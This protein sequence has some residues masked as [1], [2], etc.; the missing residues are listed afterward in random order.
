[1]KQKRIFYPFGILLMFVLLLMQFAF[2]PE[3]QDSVQAQTDQVPDF[4]IQGP[5]SDAPVY[6]TVFNGDLRHLSQLT[7]DSPA[8]PLPLKYIPGQEPK[9]SAPQLAG[10]QD[11]VIQA[12][13]GSG[14]MPNPI[15]NF[16]GL[17]FNTFGSGHPPDT[18]G[19]VGPNHYIQTVN[20]SIGIYDKTTGVRL[21]G[22]SFNNFFQGGTACNTSNSG[23]PIVI[24]DPIAHRWI[25]TD[26]AWFNSNTGPYYECIAVSQTNDPVSGGWYFYEMRAD[27]GAFT[28]YLND[29]PKLGVWPDG[30]YMTAN[31]FQIVAP[32]TGFGVRTWALDRTSMMGGGPLNEVHFDLCTNAE[33]GSLLPSNLRGDLPPAGSP[34]YFATV[35]PP[36]LFQIWE[37]DVDWT[38]PAN[39]TFTG[40]VDVPVADFVIAQSVPQLGTSNLLDSLSFR[41]MMQLQYRTIKGVESLWVNH[42]VAANNGVGGV[43]W[44][45]IH[46]PGG[47]PALAQ[48]STYQPDDHH[49]WMGSTAVDKDGNMAVGYSVSSGSMFPAIRYSGRLAGEIPG[50]L[51]QS[52]TTL[53]AGTGSQFGSSRW[54]DY[55]TMTVDPNDD[56][57]FWFTTEYYISSGSNWQTRIGSFKFPSCGQAKAYL[58]GYV[59][60]SATSQ[61]VGGVK[62][63]ANAVTQTLTVQT[64]TSGYYSMTLLADTFNLTAGPLLPG[65]PV[66]S[67]V[68]GVT[69]VTGSVTA[70]DFYLNPVPNLE[71]GGVQI[72][73]DVMFGNN[74]G[75]LEPGEQDVLLWEGLYNSGAITGTNI[76]AVLSSSTPGVIIN[77]DTAAYPNIAASATMT[78]LTPFLVSLDS[79]VNCGDDLDF[80]KIISSTEGTYN[81]DFTLNASVPQLQADVFNNDVESGAQGWT[82]GGIGNLWGITTVES[83]S[84]THSWSDSPSGN[85]PTNANSYLQTPAYNLAG[86]RHV[87]LSG[88]YKYALEAGYDYVYLEYSLN[89]GSTWATSTP[90]YSFNGVESQWTEIVIDASVLDGQPNVALRWRL[91]SDGGV[92][93]DGIYIDDVVLSY[94]PFTCDYVAPTAGVS[95]VGDAAASGTP[96]TAVTY[97]LHITN[98]GSLTDTFDLTASGIWTPTLSTN[99]ITLTSGA[100]STFTVIVA[101]PPNAADADNDTTSVTATSTFDPSTSAAATLTSTAVIPPSYGVSLSGDDA[102]TGAPGTAVTYTLHITN[103]GS[104]TDTFDLTASGVWTPTLSTHSITLTSGASTTMTVV[105][106]IPGSA[107][108]GD[109][110]QAIITATSTLDPLA[111]DSVT[112]T[113]TAQAQVSMT[114]IYLPVIMKP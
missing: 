24:Y 15:A 47:T 5:F 6:P 69:A 40:P 78:N 2:L 12:Q 108:N 16:P 107:T 70:T 88:W 109:S 114:Y 82:T 42:T 27:T 80:H 55:S 113:T 76:T 64:D 7:G 21:V 14:Q 84:P 54:G 56:C 111:S 34:N 18:N 77:T 102:A 29:Y 106:P 50:Q 96:G 53:I 112:L 48:Q 110:N 98:S 57:T 72:D 10:W 8:I 19:D 22:L 45:E 73:D 100:S 36:G 41:P 43:R 86:K 92:E 97:T 91:T 68:T 51:P 67:T 94:E 93:D 26:F 75:Y 23:D 38:T 103:S 13:F 74:N 71:E 58:D 39:S 4:D 11:T 35:T 66:S 37:F 104:L 1:M 33:C 83:N 63:M 85:Y 81:V 32:G 44:Y 17:D 62:V 52:E 28:G 90:L 25:V 87:R 89:G 95:L 65:Y 105:I 30:W 99:S 46:D 20:T 61:P 9:G 49:R 3:R 59:Y 101:I 31:M 60:N 79:S